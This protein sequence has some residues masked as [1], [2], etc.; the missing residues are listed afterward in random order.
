MSIIRVELTRAR[1]LLRDSAYFLK[2]FGITCADF[3]VL[4]IAVT[5]PGAALSEVAETTDLSKPTL[6]QIVARLEAAGLVHLT[7]AD[8]LG[9]YKN[10]IRLLRATEKGEVVYHEA[11]QALGG[12]TFK[13]QHVA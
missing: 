4:E 2:D 7:L 8:H 13:K 10:P 3:E 1:A 9:K 12:P 11:H 6:R 5:D